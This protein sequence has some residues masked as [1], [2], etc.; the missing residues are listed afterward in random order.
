MIE[1]VLSERCTRCNACVDVC[2]TNVFEAAKDAPP[3]IA[4]QDDCETCFMCELYCPAD[5]L[6]VGPDC[7][8]SE[9]VS[10]AEIELSGWLGQFRRDSG[11]GEWAKDP[12][13]RNQHWRMDSVFARA[14]QAATS[15]SR[16]LGNG[17]S[18]RPGAA[19]ERVGPQ[20]GSP[21]MTTYG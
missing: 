1:L 16:G 18:A 9:P 3:E 20:G 12:R 14:R 17:Q 10:P 7:D 8:R 15:T 11:W 2:P 21:G 4:R 19:E 13:Y 5:A 6:F